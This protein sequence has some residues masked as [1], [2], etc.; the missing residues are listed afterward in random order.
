MSWSLN[1]VNRVA[2]WVCGGVML[3]LLAAVA[4]LA[5]QVSDLSE[6]AGTLTSERDTARD[7]RDEARAETALQAMNFNRVNQIT[8]EARRVRQ[9]SATFGAIFTRI[10]RRSPAVACCCL[11]MI[12]TGC[13]ATSTRC[14]MKPYTRMPPELLAPTLPSLPPGD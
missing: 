6:R 11:L 2:L 10:S 13:S 1:P 12:L 7:E 14:V 9:Q 4:V 5:Y 8:E 3:A